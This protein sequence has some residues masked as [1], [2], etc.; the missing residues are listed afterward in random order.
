MLLL[1]WLEIH[2]RKVI[3]GL[4][5]FRLEV[6][7]TLQYLLLS[8]YGIATPKTIPCTSNETIIKA[9]SEIGDFII[10]DNQGGSGSGVYRFEGKDSI[11]KLKEHLQQHSYPISPDKITLVQ[12]YIKSPIR[13]ITRVEIV[14]GRHLY[15]LSVDTSKGFLVN[16]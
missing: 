1:N 10:K 15:S 6:D 2:K 14:G 7:K 8:Q 9:A 13:K 5:A 3:N 12:E 11:Q 4:S 16:W